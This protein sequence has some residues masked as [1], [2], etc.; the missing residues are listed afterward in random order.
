MAKVEVVMP[1]LGESL[2]EGTIIKWHKKPGD[3]VKKD[4]TLLEISTDKVDSEI[5]S[6]VSGVVTKLLF[7]EQKTVAVRTVIAEI[8]TDA[9][10][11]VIESASAASPIDAP[12]P[13]TAVSTP[14][15][16]TPSVSAPV[17]TTPTSGRFYSPLVLSIAR[18]EGISM[19]ELETIPG[20]GEGGRVSKK[21]ILAFVDARKK[22]APMPTI[23][24]LPAAP[25]PTGPSAPR[26]EASLK[27]IDSGEL[28]K[29]YPSP[30]YEILKMSNVLQKMSEHM[31]RSVQTSP[32]V[33]AVHEC[34][35]TTVDMLRRKH[36]GTFEKRE[37]FKLTFMPFICDAVVKALKQY[38]LVNSSVEGDKI[39]L[40]HFINLGIAVASENGLIVPVIKNAEE[41]NF[42]G[43]ARAVNDLA[44]RTRSKRLTPADIENGTFTV[45]NYGVFGTMIGIPII[46]QPQVAILGIGAAKKRPVI[47]NDAIATRSISYLTLSFDHRIIDGALGGSFLEAIV[48]NLE[49]FD[50]KQVM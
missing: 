41:K 48:K 30:Q 50:E 35:M 44:T 21:D 23:Q 5:P 34:D 27:H 32:H 38:P 17:A 22:G 10:A 6:P 28:A 45:T 14:P 42:I 29:K 31:V 9:S 39:I 8:E 3:K 1:Q 46:N 25:T 4:E 2:T 18:E 12:K 33:Q 43:L 26:I 37:G 7:E 11:A 19:Q 40:K 49:N 16:L 36:A 24:P 13:A 15:K 47:I 20:T